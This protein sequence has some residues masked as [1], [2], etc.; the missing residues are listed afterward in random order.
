LPA[1]SWLDLQ[2]VVALIL[3]SS[4]LLAFSLRRS[5]IFPFIHFAGQFDFANLLRL[6][7]VVEHFAAPKALLNY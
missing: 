1:H 4:A 5:L 6:P 7:F 2:R 3:D